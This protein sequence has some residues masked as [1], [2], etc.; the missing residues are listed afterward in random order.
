VPSLQTPESL[1]F[2]VRA[3]ASCGTT[4]TFSAVVQVSFNPQCGSPYGKVYH[5]SGIGHL[6]GV[7]PAFWYSDMAVFNPGESTAQMRLT[8]TGNAPALAPVTASLPGRQQ[9]AWRDVLVSL[10]GLGGEDVGAIAVESTQPLQVSART[11][12]RITDACD[13]RQK[14]YGQ[15]YEGIEPSQALAN[16]QVGYLVN[17][18]SDGGFRTNVEFV[19]A[20]AIAA[21]VEVR[22]FNGGGVQVGSPLNRG[23]TPN[24]RVGVTAALP[25]GQPTAFA[26]VRVT[27][28]GARVIGFASVIDGASTDP[29]TIPMLVTGTTSG[30]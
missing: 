1:Y 25:S 5:V 24:Q 28:A 21:S 9:L 3:A 6:R 8:F 15:S 11:Y 23:L 19:N 27:P 14:T 10:F 2:R 7:A 16:G 17:L 26:E 22:F 13:G 4:S 12:S 29:T 20:G 18:R 30:R